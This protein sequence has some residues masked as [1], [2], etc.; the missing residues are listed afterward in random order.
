MKRYNNLYDEMISIQNINNIYFNQIRKNIKNKKKI[1]KFEENYGININDILNK[2]KNYETCK[3][4][5]FLIKDP[6]YRI[7]MS[8][9][10]KDKIINHLVGNT[11]IK[12]LDK[13]L[14]DGNVA[15]RK[16]K[17]THYGIKLLKKYLNELKEKE[18]Y[19]L[20]FDI[21]KYFYNI[22]HKVLK[23]LYYSK[24]KDKK[25]LNLLDIIIGGTNEKYVN[26]V[27][28]S[29][30]KKEIQKIKKSKL[31]EKQKT[32]KINEL[33]KVPMYEK[34][35]GLPIGNMTSQ[36]LAIFYLN[37]LDHFIK[38]KLK[39]KYIRYM[40]DGLL[41]SN[42]KKHLKYC[43]KE[44]TKIT[45]RYKL[46]LNNKTQ[47]INVSKNGIDFLGFR[48]YIINNKIIMKVRNKTKKKFKRVIK[49]KRK[50]EK[51][52]QII[53]SY[54]SHLKW[55]NCYNLIYKNILKC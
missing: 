37:E 15:T 28:T 55:G 5:I 2:L 39:V 36:I 7:I 24:I 35:K 45:N 29:L 42:D 30:I 18:I 20:K 10:I 9:N 34:G 8:L 1:Y 12:I 46:K 3:Y 23:D 33:K 43:L 52:T 6:K 49:N 38:E 11:L 50:E 26:I 51:Y 40:D 17:G 13:S 14:I 32:L 54:K 44:I 21:E 48:F 19:A 22:D 25:I 31:S 16:G 47:I 4:N 53:N 27:I 41:L